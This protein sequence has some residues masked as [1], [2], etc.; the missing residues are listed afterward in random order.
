MDAKK[1]FIHSEWF[2]DEEY[3]STWLNQLSWNDDVKIDNVIF[4]GFGS[5]FVYLD[6]ISIFLKSG[7]T[8]EYLYF[9][10]VSVII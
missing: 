8:E 10:K 6:K 2:K 1:Y 3:I 5:Y 7:L 9:Q 4:L